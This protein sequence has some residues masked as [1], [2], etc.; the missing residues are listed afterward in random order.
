MQCVNSF[1]AIK[2]IELW[3]RCCPLQLKVCFRLFIFKSIYPS[4]RAKIVSLFLLFCLVVEICKDIGTKRETEK[5]LCFGTTVR[6]RQDWFPSRQ[7]RFE[8]QNCCTLSHPL[9]EQW[10]HNIGMSSFSSDKAA[11]SIH[12]FLIILFLWRWCSYW[13]Q[14]M[15]SRCPSCWIR[16]PNSSPGSWGVP[17]PDGTNGRPPSPCSGSPPI[18]MCLEGIQREVSGLVRRPRCSWCLQYNLFFVISSSHFSITSWQ[19]PETARFISDWA[20]F[21]QTYKEKKVVSAELLFQ[22]S[23]RVSN[24]KKAC[25]CN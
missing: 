17:R 18:W 13:G 21:K 22:S 10:Y 1:F 8:G 2:L 16:S 11:F 7:G 9:V 5:E 20:R 3:C 24:L 19:R 23:D 14:G 15:C 12:P 25:A 4:W 6:R